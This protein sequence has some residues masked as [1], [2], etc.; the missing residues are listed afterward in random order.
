ML[1]LNGTLQ[2]AKK[3]YMDFSKITVFPVSFFPICCKLAMAGYGRVLTMNFS[4]PDSDFLLD[5]L[6][7][8]GFSGFLF[9]ETFKALWGGGAAG[10]LRIEVL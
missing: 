2:R 7:L 4:S 1:I 5:S 6:K 3:L 10:P 9:S 8:L